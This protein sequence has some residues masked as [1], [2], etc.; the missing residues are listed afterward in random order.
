MNEKTNERHESEMLSQTDQS[1]ARLLKERL[2][3]ITPLENLVVYGSRARGDSSPDSDMDV[4]IE[5]PGITP[6]L[7]RSISE[8]AWEV[9]FKNGIIISTFV[10]T[11]MDIKEGP[12]GANPLVKAVKSEGVPV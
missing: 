1:I 11:P 12:I 6:E 7:R 3:V 10:V 5:V 8:I 4:Y 9:G 2:Q